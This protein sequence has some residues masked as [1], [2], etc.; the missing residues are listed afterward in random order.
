MNSVSLYPEYQFQKK[1]VRIT[2]PNIRQSLNSELLFKI[3]IL[4]AQYF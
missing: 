1:T 2:L 4:T 3:L